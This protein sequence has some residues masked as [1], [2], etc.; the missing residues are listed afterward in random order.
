M[1]NYDVF[2]SK[3]NSQDQYARLQEHIYNGKAYTQEEISYYAKGLSF[4]FMGRVKVF[5]AQALAGIGLISRHERDARIAA[6]VNRIG[7]TLIQQIGKNTNYYQQHKA[8]KVS[9]FSDGDRLEEEIP[10]LEG[11]VELLTPDQEA[12]IRLDSDDIR[13]ATLALKLALSEE[14]AFKD[15]L[16]DLPGLD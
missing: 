2:K 15:I 13:M 12:K 9:L 5:F 4:G 6:E 7:R 16:P 1:I 14:R 11:R 3:V 8:E 10:S